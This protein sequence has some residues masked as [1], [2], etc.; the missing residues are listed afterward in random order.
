MLDKQAVLT[1]LETAEKETVN[2]TQQTIGKTDLV[3]KLIAAIKGGNFDV[4]NEISANESQVIAPTE[5][6]QVES[7]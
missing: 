6:L 7:A 5:N 2:F 1:A 3:G 4:K